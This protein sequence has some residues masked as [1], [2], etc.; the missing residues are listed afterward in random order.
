MKA[1]H[2]FLADANVRQSQ[3]F[4]RSYAKVLQILRKKSSVQD[5]KNLWTRVLLNKFVNPAL[6]GF[7]DVFLEF[8]I[9][10]SFLR[11]LCLDNVEGE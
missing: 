5:R 9:F 11:A 8:T 2:S 3:D 4:V 6:K 1:T 7:D 10:L